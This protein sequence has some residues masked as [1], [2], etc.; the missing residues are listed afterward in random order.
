MNS[1]HTVT[2][3]KEI[4]LVAENIAHEKGLNPQDIIDAMAMGIKVAA[5][6]KYGSDLSID[7]QI[8][9]KSGEIKLYNSL[10]VVDEKKLDE[11]D[12][13]FNPKI[14]IYLDDARK[15]DADLNLDDE[16]LQ[17]LPPI[18]LNRVVAQI[19]RN[20]ITQK[21]KEAEKNKE[22]EEF[23][24]RVGDIISATVK[25]IGLKNVVMD[26]EGYE[27]VL[28]ESHM[29]PKEAFKVGSRTRVYIDDVK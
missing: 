18:D 6:K 2:G 20:E 14:H 4:L 23:K 21:V 15:Q 11:E 12:E 17:E 3:N 22:Y 26:A 25:K 19:A 16:I 5:K 7:C 27:A 8:D 29:I 9:R 13:E 10:R 28:H 24:D 1:T